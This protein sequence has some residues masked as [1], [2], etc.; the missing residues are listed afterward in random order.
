[1]RDIA[2][3]IVHCSDTAG[4]TVDTIRK[5]H[6]H[7]K[8][9]DD[10]GYHYVIH[11]DGEIAQGRDVE[12]VGAHCYGHNDDSIGVCMIGVNTFTMKQIVSLKVLL[13]RLVGHHKLDLTKI[14]CHYELDSKGKTCPN[15]EIDDLRKIYRG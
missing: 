4:G 12:K 10:I 7:E 2:K 9:W 8:G 1:M 5:Y 13:Q 15:F 3:I 6:I 14:F 11:R